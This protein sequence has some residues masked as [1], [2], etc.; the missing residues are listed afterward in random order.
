M[1]M[2]SSCSKQR[3]EKIVAYISHN[4]SRTQLT[5]DSRFRERRVLRQ[6][7]QRK[8]AIAAA[9]PTIPAQCRVHFRRQLMPLSE[10]AI[11]HAT[12]KGTAI[13]VPRLG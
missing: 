6:D 4:P 2:V 10:Q 7:E 9:N 12:N 13:R 3:F 11:A 1:F 5:A 8:S